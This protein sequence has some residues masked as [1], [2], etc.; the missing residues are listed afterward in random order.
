MIR[1]SS[2][3]GR[4]LA[5]SPRSPSR[6]AGFTLI[7]IMIVLAII[8]ILAAVALPGYQDSVRK[9]WRNKATSC[10]TEMAQSMERRFTANMSYVGAALPGNACVVEDGMAARY[11]FDFVAAPAANAFELR[12]TPQ[13]AQVADTICAILTINQVGVRTVSGTGGVNDCWQ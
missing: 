9:T 1:T 5:R 7:E 8:A 2:L 6:Q 10:L 12:A 11:A 4:T 13:G 3:P